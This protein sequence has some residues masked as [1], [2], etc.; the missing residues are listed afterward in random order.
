[1]GTSESMVPQ[2]AKP[3]AL[4][5]VRRIGVSGPSSSTGLAL[6]VTPWKFP[7]SRPW[8]GLAASLAGEAKPRVRLVVIGE[9]DGGSEPRLRLRVDVLRREAMVEGLGEVGSGVAGPHEEADDE[10]DE[11]GESDDE[12]PHEEL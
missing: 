11:L 5:P 7:R 8:F 6:M 1:M 2:N 12:R 10:L 9:G 3:L 4:R